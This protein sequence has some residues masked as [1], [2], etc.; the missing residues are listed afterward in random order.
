M[1]GQL[2]HRFASGLVLEGYADWQDHPDGRDASTLE[3]LA[4]WQEKTWRASLQYG[5]QDRR[6]SGPGGSDLSLD[7][8]SAFAVVQ[9]SSKVAVLGRADRN[10][11]PIPNGETI[12]YM[13]FSDRVPSVFGYLGVD[14]TLAKTVH[15]IP[16]V[17]MTVYDEATDGSTPGTDLVP[18]LTLFFSW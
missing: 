4:G 13:P 10:F 1:R 6:E 2:V 9:V 14:V 11:D 8:L 12:D 16:N 3:A 17:E 15:L 7:F 5:H 18:R